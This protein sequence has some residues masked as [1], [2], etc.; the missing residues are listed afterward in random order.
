[1]SFAGSK[2]SDDLIQMISD[3]QKEVCE[4]KNIYGK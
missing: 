4:L 1:M 2:T 3:L